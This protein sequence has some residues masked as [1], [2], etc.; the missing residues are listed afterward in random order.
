MSKYGR[1]L[2]HRRRRLVSVGRGENSGQRSGESSGERIGVGG[3]TGDWGRGHWGRSGSG[4][5]KQLFEHA[6][7]PL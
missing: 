7:N 5:S 2:R 4:T 3:G 6:F 1:S